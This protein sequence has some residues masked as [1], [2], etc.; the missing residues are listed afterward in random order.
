MCTQREAQIS[1]RVR[2]AMR[3]LI[4]ALALTR[5]H[6]ALP[7]RMGMLNRMLMQVDPPDRVEHFE[8]SFYGVNAKVSLNM[9]TRVAQVSLN[10]VALGGRIS[11]TGWL[12]DFFSEAGSVVLDPEFE[13]RLK[14][15]M[16]TIYQARL[17]RA[18][19][20]VTVGVKIPVLGKVDLVLM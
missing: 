11:G 12:D 13:R 5:T 17:D 3:Q 10:G 9:R 19:H 18:N 20:T 8:G 6:H 16:V 4:L 2:L 14:R 15:R 1:V 7:P